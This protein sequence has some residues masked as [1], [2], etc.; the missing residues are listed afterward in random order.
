MDC[1]KYL[2]LMSAALDGELTAEERRDLDSHLA[3]CPE[4][5]EL[6]CRLTDQT[7]ALRD[8]DCEVPTGLKE[9]IMGSLPE[10]DKPTKKIKPVRWTPKTG[11]VIHWKRWAPVAAAACLALVIALV[12]KSGISNNAAPGAQAPAAAEPRAPGAPMPSSTTESCKTNSDSTC[13]APDSPSM[14]S[15]EMGGLVDPAEPAAQEPQPDAGATQ[16]TTPPIGTEE[17]WVTVSLS[18]EKQRSIQINGMH[19]EPGAVVIGSVESLE[20]YLNQFKSYIAEDLSED[21]QILQNY[22][23]YEQFF[24]SERLLCVLVETDRYGRPQ[25]ASGGLYRDRVTVELTNDDPTFAA[26]HFLIVA[27]VSS[28]VFEDGDTL[29]VSVSKADGRYYPIQNIWLQ[30]IGISGRTSSSATVIRSTEELT[31]YLEHN[32]YYTD[33]VTG[34]LIRDPELEDLVS[35]YGAPIPEWFFESRTLLAFKMSCPVYN[36]RYEV[37]TVNS[38]AVT[39]R[40]DH[41]FYGNSCPSTWLL[42]VEAHGELDPDNPPQLV[43]E[44]GYP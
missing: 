42:L 33:Q 40:Q 21:L 22:Y 14:G 4:C 15:F 5:A 17:H 37:L 27:E 1:D 16:E 32:V 44:D 23:G 12:P 31:E 25:L 39:V 26:A 10:Q 30:R 13:D 34:E 24:L 19:P 41:Y 11:K 7:A 43:V 6:Y 28:N 3:V 2:E 20:N 36:P 18:F 8:L 9:R 29:E 35:M 38:E